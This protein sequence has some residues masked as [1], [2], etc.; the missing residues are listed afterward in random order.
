MLF[1]SPDF[2]LAEIEIKRFGPRGAAPWH[3]LEFSERAF[4]PAHTKDG[5]PSFMMDCKGTVETLSLAERNR[6]LTGNF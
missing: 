1:R 6:F 4:F 5:I 3:G 2:V